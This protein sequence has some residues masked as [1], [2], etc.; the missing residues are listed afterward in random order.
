M[1]DFALAIAGSLALTGF[2]ALTPL[3][4]HVPER[5]RAPL[6]SVSGGAGLAYVFLYLLFELATDGAPKIHALVPL[7]PAPLET[8]FILLLGAI[9]VTYVLQVQLEKTSDPRDDHH[10][11]ALLFM[12][13]NFLA[14][15]GLVEEARGGALNLAFYVTAIGLHLLFNDLFLLHLCHSAHT[16]RWRSALAAAPLLGCTLAAGLGLPSGALYGML[17]LVAGGTIINVLRHELPD[18]RSFH[19]YAF[20]GGVVGYAALIFATWRF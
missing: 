15:A 5:Q 7:G 6:T 3:L 12:T 10:G 9:T 2:H 11:F 18:L 17:A 8:L 16:W 20:I 4:E 13:Y 19:P 14:G 1:N